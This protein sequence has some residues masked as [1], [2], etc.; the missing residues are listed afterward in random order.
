MSVVRVERLRYK[1]C[2][3]EFRKVLKEEWLVH[4]VGEVGSVEEEWMAFKN[5]V[6]RCAEN[7]CGMKRLSK[8]G[9]RKGS[10]WWNEEME[11]LVRRKREVY[12]LWLQNRCR[13]AYEK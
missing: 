9:I 7:V 6:N 11:G 2:K 3:E 4:K 1:R 8:R 10:E 5:A 13:E 12:R